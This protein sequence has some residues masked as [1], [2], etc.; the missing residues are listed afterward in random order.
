MIKR[1]PTLAAFRR[2]LLIL[3][4]SLFMPAF[5]SGMASELSAHPHIW[6]DV[7]LTPRMENGVLRSIEVRWEFDE[8]YSSG[9][10]ADFDTNRD[11]RFTG[12]EAEDIYE[13]AFVHLADVGYFMTI[14]DSRGPVDPGIARDFSVDYQ[15]GRLIYR[16]TLDVNLNLGRGGEV[17][18]LSLD[19]SNYI[20]F[21]TAGFQTRG[22]SSLRAS[23][24]NISVEVV[25]LGEQ[26]LPALYVSR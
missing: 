5:F 13:N 8:W 14:E 22:D 6:I 26:R 7:Y 4:L 20:A 17:V 11:R 23:I 16:F 3:A 21:F 19:P 18:A 9:Y 1:V 25:G 2:Y 15:D 24:E 10:L 12:R